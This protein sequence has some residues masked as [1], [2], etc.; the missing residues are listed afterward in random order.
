MW[1]IL[2]EIP[3]GLIR[4]LFNIEFP[5]AVFSVENSRAAVNDK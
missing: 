4:T 2:Y 5:Y 1:F 3:S